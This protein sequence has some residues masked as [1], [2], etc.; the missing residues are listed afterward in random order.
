MKINAFEDLAN[1]NKHL[2]ANPITTIGYARK[3]KGRERFTTRCNLLSKMVERLEAQCLCTK[4][5]VS[6]SS[7][8]NEELEKRDTNSNNSNYLK[9][10]QVNGDMKDLCRLLNT[11]FKPVRLVA[12]DFAGLTTEPN[13]LRQFI[14]KYTQIQEVVI[15][16]GVTFSIYSRHD[17]L[18]NEDI[19]S[20]FN[21]RTGFIRRSS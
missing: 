7:N 21:C 1:Y 10:L 5:F 15:D 4:I 18:E 14:R 17:L 13:D 12:I 3:S 9:A 8:A 6:P 16:H 20:K 11:K 19:I 2:R